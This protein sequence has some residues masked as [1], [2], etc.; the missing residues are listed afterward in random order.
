MESSPGTRRRALRLAL[1]V[2][3][4]GLLI[5]AKTAGG[6]GRQLLAQEAAATPA[7]PL[8]I[9]VEQVVAQRPSEIRSGSCDDSSETV[10]PLTALETPEGEA[11]G[12]GTA[13]EAARSYTELPIGMDELL[14]GQTNVTVF[15]SAEQSETVIA[16]G[17]IGGVPGEAGS[18]VIK[19]S[20]QN[21]S[22]F[23][24][25]AFLA[26][27][28]E[29]TTGVSVFLAGKRTVAETRELAAAT[30]AEELAALPEPTPTVEPVQ[31]VD[32]ALLEWL[33]DLPEEMRAGQVNFVV[34]NEGSEPHSLVIEGQDF[35]AELPRPLDPDQT[36]ILNATL[37]AGEYVVYC[38]LDNGSHREKG[39]EATLV[40]AL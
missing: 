4:L 24:G 13:I 21:D 25:I 30:P 5:A 33:I 26:P 35:S 3:T 29:A 36:T 18:V 15:L 2:L 11:Q 38:P 23:S 31:A 32:V 39:M 14:A 10:A 28:D 7:T 27:A 19:L 17:E 6:H 16:C 9:D 1:V 8:P 34:T 40:V 22:G 20:P 12:Q 37:P